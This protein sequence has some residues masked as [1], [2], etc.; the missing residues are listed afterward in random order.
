[1]NN[2]WY[3]QLDLEKEGYKIGQI[4]CID[5]H[6][7]NPKRVVFSQRLG[8]LALQNQGGENGYEG[9]HFGDFTEYDGRGFWGSLGD[10]FRLPLHAKNKITIIGFQEV[11]IIK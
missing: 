2:I 3:P 4:V 1:M 6:T 9:D 10:C 5:E 11:I 8:C 7:R